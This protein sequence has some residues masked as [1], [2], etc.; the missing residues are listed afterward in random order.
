MVLTHRLRDDALLVGEQ[1][2]QHRVFRRRS[3]GLLAAGY[4]CAVQEL[5][6]ETT[7]V[8]LSF[9]TP[10][11]V[12]PGFPPLILFRETEQFFVSVVSCMPNCI[13]PDV[14]EMVFD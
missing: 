14:S 6:R 10:R 11:L 12:F 5:S 4:Q 9:S 7:F 2:S 1:R 8:L 13:F 3:R